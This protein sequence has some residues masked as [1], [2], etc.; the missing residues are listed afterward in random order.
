M[1]L[2]IKN[3]ISIRLV[4][5]LI[6]AMIA[7]G[8]TGCQSKKKLARQQAAKELA[9]KIEKAKKDLLMVINDQGAMSISQKEKIVDDVKALNLNNEEV[10]A[11]IIEAEK[12]I[13]RHKKLEAQRL[14][15]ERLRKEREAAEQRKI[16]E[17]KFDKMEDYF[18]AIASASTIDIANMRINDA[19]KFFASPEVPVLIIVYQD[20]E[21][22]DYDRPTTIKQYLEHL[23]DQKKNINRVHNIEYDTKGKIVELELIKK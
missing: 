16:E 6:A 14:E 2:K 22:T 21:I 20:N 4:F 19:L 13:E 7:V 12:A 1:L 15:E 18:D 3:L 5:L 17:Q 11:L 8:F 9:E 23:K 10:D